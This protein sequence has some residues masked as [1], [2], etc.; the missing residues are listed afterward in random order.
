MV[1]A[2]VRI[3]RPSARP[4]PVGVDFVFISTACYHTTT[5]SSSLLEGAPW[6]HYHTLIAHHQV[7]KLGAAGKKRPPVETPIAEGNIPLV[8]N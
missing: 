1:G 7:A 8:T 4:R 5:H 3:T 6:L 2:G